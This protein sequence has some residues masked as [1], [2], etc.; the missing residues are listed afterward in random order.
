[1]KEDYIWGYSIQP[2]Y[3]VEIL[4]AEPYT[5]AEKLKMFWHDHLLPALL[6]TFS[7]GCYAYF[8]ASIFKWVLG[9]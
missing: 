8:V 6:Q 7:I 1:M 2:E 4:P 9:L 5:R 3:M